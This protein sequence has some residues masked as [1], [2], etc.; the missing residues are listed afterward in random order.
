MM[1]RSKAP[2]RIGLAG[3]GTD[4]SPYSDIFGGAILNATISL[5]ARATIELLPDK[6]IV[7]V[8][9]D[10]QE[11]EQYDWMPELPLNGKLDLLKGIFNAIRRDYDLQPQGLRLTTFVDVPAGSGLGTSSTLVV[12]IL[13]AFAEMLKL[14]LGEYDLAHYAYHIERIELKLAGGKQDQY[15]ATFGGINFMEF[16]AD[17]KVIV[18]P[19]RVKHQYLH[20]LENNLL[21]YYTSVSRDSAEFIIRQSNNVKENK[22]PS[23]QAMHQLKE[24]SVMMKEALL[25]GQIDKIGEILNYGYEQKRKMAEGI[26]NEFLDEIY[27]AARKAGATGGKIS[28]AGGGGFMIFYCP[29]N[30][31]FN[32]I[33][34]LQPYGG[35]VYPYQFTKYGLTTWTTTEHG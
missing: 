13:G 30:T 20:E 24:Q 12:A 11:T 29:G 31:K 15:A 9:Q 25:R 1:Y 18:N 33:E 10:R 27:E 23:I 4:V 8:A 16:Y 32:V 3:G 35:K 17:D 7:L 28:G 5:F 26:T 19:L 2:L 34:A 22:E 14:P 21:L 6:K